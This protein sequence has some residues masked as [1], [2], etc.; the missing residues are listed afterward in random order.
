M[1]MAHDERG[2]RRLGF[3]AAVLMPVVGFGLYGFAK[4]DFVALSVALVGALGYLSWHISAESHYA[5]LFRSIA[6][7]VLDARRGAGDT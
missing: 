6:R 4:R 5:R 1:R 2:A 7:K 3:Y